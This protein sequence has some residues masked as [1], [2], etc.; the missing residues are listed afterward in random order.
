M[1]IHLKVVMKIGWMQKIEVFLKEILKKKFAVLGVGSNLRGDDGV[2]PYISEKLSEYNSDSF[3]SINGDLVPE[4]FTHDL[5]EFNPNCVLIIDAAFLEKSPGEV[6]LIKANAIKN[7]SF[8]SHS[9][10][11]SILGKYLEQKIGA[12]IYIMGIQAKSLDF[13]SDMSEEVKKTAD[14]LIEIFKK[15]LA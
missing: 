1:H 5:S 6:D 14:K 2:G 4:N 13:G 11:L 7:V 9:M 8:S 12:S 3:L 10:P 15:E